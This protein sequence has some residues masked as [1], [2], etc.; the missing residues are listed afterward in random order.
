LP[1][2]LIVLFDIDGTLVRKAGPHHGRALEDAVHQVTGRRVSIAGIPVFGMLDSDILTEMMDAAGVARG[3]QRE[4]RAQIQARAQQL[5]R[6]TCPDLRPRVIPGV[7]PLLRRLRRAGAKLGLV[8]G[9][10]TRIGWHKVERAGL[11][12]HFAFGGFAGMGP[13]RAALARRAMDHA[14]R[15]GWLTPHARVVLIGD[16]PNDVEAARANGILS[17]AVA[18]GHY[19]AADLRPHGPAVLVENLAELPPER[20]WA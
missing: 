19:S 20:L 4:S 2:P 5:Y 8:T 15:Q 10:F 16:T 9:N 11:R 14:R 17:V 1:P 6:R 13:T 18:T 7:R 3:V 12:G